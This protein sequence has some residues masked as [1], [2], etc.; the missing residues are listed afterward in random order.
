MKALVERLTTQNAKSVHIQPVP[1]QPP[2]TAE[3]TET[4]APVKN[5]AARKPLDPI[6]R[7]AHRI[8]V[9]MFGPSKA[10]RVR[11]AELEDERAQAEAELED[12]LGKERALLR[13]IHIHDRSEQEMIAAMAK[14]FRKD[15]EWMVEQRAGFYRP[16]KQIGVLHPHTNIDVEA[17]CMAWLLVRKPELRSRFNIAPDVHIE[18]VKS[19]ELTAEAAPASLQSVPKPFLTARHLED[20]GH[21]FVDCG[22]GGGL[23]DQHG[24]EENKGRNTVSS[25]HLL[26]TSVIEYIPALIHLVPLFEMV[27][28]N[29]LT[30]ERVAEG[31]NIRDFLNGLLELGL[32]SEEIL[33]YL[34]VAFDAA[35][36]FLLAKQDEIEQDDA[37]IIQSFRAVRKQVL[38]METILANLRAPTD[39][40]LQAEAT[41]EVRYLLKEAT[42]SGTPMTAGE[43]QQLLVT[44]LQNARERGSRIT[45][46]HDR[47]R[48]IE[49]EARAARQ[50][51]WEQANADWEKA[52]VRPL[53]DGKPFVFAKQEMSI[54]GWP[55]HGFLGKVHLVIGESNSNSFGPCCRTHHSR[56]QQLALARALKG[57]AVSYHIAREASYKYAAAMISLQLR[58]VTRGP[59]GKIVSYHFTLAGNGIDLTRVASAIRR[60]HARWLDQQGAAQIDD[61]GTEARNMRAQLP[62]TRDVVAVDYLP[63]FRTVYGNYF[64]TNQEMPLWTMPVRILIEAIEIGMKASA[65]IT[66]RLLQEKR[67]RVKRLIAPVY[68]RIEELKLEARA[69]ATE[70]RLSER[71]QPSQPESSPAAVTTSEDND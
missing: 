6:E 25:L 20:H 63:E 1:A 17:A 59:D 67:I 47:F 61:P 55:F 4:A 39:A 42:K 71:N 66:E 21:L 30:G 23:L 9:A 65:E 53:N 2:E 22:G 40:D 49:K 14:V 10:K 45:A 26:I 3:V 41:A 33:D 15:V 48:E 44:S 68:Q 8:T 31:Y 56:K 36:A 7:I 16:V 60:R 11:S 54:A 28:N 51:A 18:C 69:A 70:R 5:P 35:E 50:A 12:P 46:F 52:E 32:S 62:G 43:E 58:D 19:G 57:P 29:D 38:T 34:F 13:E 27:I 37:S 24:R 64:K